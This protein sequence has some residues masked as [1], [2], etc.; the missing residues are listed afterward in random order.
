MTRT[1]TKEM[2]AK[3]QNSILAHFEDVESLKSE[4]NHYFKNYGYRYADTMVQGGC[5]DCYYSQC[6]ETMA[7]WF[8]CT[9]DAIWKYYKEDSGKLWESYKHLICRELEHIRNDRIYIK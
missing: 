1:T 8:D 9:V 7:N 3:I 4:I 2:M 5:F 6:A